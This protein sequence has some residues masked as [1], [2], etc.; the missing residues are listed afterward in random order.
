MSECIQILEEALLLCPKVMEICKDQTSD[1]I[2]IRDGIKQALL[3]QRESVIIS[4]QHAQI[5]AKI[6]ND[7]IKLDEATP[8]P[9]SIDTANELLKDLEE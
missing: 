1:A 5:L 8:L 6:V 2:L 9:C 7:V 3:T 4:K